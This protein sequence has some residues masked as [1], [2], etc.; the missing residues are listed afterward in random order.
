MDQFASLW[1]YQENI[2]ELKQKLLYTTLELEAVKAEND[3]EMK[4]NNELVKQLLESLKIACQERDEAKDQLQKL[5]NKIMVPNDQQKFKTTNP[6]MPS[7]VDHVRQ[8]HQGPLMIP[9][10]ANS[11]NTGSNSLS[12]AYNRSSSPVDSLFDPISSP[13][14]S[15]I[16]VETPFVQDYD[17]NG[18]FS[19]T[20]NGLANAQNVDQDTLVMEG[21][22]KGKTLPKKGNLL[23]A[24]VEAGPLL[25]TLLLAGPLP[26]WRNPPSIKEFHIPPMVAAVDHITT[27]QKLDV[28]F[29]TKLLKPPMM[30]FRQ[31]QP[32]AKMACGNSSQMMVVGG[33]SGG[34][35]GVL[36]F[37]D[38]N[39]S[40]TLKKQR[41]H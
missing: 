15:N 13:E 21:M 11:S 30:M 10:K 14:F 19:N 24:V 3:E 33:G 8:Y 9:A 34:S 18:G 22:I 31:S 2:D 6:L 20:M 16:N 12:E 40:T 7:C 1:S 4:R 36:S 39:L 32:Y 29:Q 38:V 25:Q 27:T 5:L 35:G 28:G 37:G 17:Q 41:L 26:K 23:K